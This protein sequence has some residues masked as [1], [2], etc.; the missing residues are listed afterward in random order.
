MR[1]RKVA[2]MPIT[3]E[4][5]DF[6]QA[7]SSFP[8]G[9]TAV[10]TQRNHLPVGII[11]TSVCSLSAD[12]PSIIVCINKNAS[13]HDAIL[14]E[15]CFAVNLLSTTHQAVVQR[16]QSHKGHDR[17]ESHLWTTLNTGAPILVNAAT[18]LDCELLDTHDGYSHTIIVGAVKATTTTTAANQDCLLWHGRGYARSTPLFAR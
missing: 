6:Q 5:V 14:A 4:V 8:G 12:P 18:A 10:T 17:F 13:L 3:V 1:T 15:K 11:A 16:F 2:T 7:M 9:I